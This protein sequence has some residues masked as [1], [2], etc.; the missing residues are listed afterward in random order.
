MALRI[1]LYSDGFVQHDYR[2]HTKCTLSLFQRKPVKADETY[3]L[4]PQIGSTIRR[5]AH[6]MYSLTLWELIA[7]EH[8]KCTLSLFQRKPAEAH[9]TYSLASQIGSTFRRKAHE[10]YSLSACRDHTPFSVPLSPPLSSRCQ[11]T[12]ETVGGEGVLSRSG[13]DQPHVSEELMKRWRVR[14]QT[15]VNSMHLQH[16]G[17][18]PMKQWGVRHRTR[19]VESTRNVLSHSPMDPLSNEKHTKCTLSFPG[20]QPPQNM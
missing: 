16:L 19:L 5:K 8:T 9:E 3:S 20:R 18:E 11:R 14:L 13:S 1:P 2:K 4:A 10:T 7:P 6:E 15:P 17:K 12:H